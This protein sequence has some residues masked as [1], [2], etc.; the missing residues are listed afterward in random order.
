MRPS[1]SSYTHARRA[2]ARISPDSTVGASH[3]ELDGRFSPPDLEM[4]N[5]ETDVSFNQLPEL[6]RHRT[7]P[8]QVEMERSN[9]SGAL[10]DAVEPENSGVGLDGAQAP[11]VHIEYQELYDIGQCACPA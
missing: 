5:A 6:N 8:K 1:P 2:L 10:K 4:A 11:D 9:G 3:L 7:E